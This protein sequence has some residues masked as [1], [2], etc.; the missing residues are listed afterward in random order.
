MFPNLFCMSMLP[1][2]YSLYPQARKVYIAYVFV[3]PISVIFF[4]FTY[5]SYFDNLGF[6][7]FYTSPSDRNCVVMRPP[8]KIRA[9]FPRSMMH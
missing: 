7:A 8:W 6:F 2:T 4:T 5:N 9:F 3:K 1:A